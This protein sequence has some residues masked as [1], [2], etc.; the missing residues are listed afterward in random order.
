MDRCVDELTD[1]RMEVGE[2]LERSLDDWIDM[3]WQMGHLMAAW[4][5]VGY[6]EGSLILFWKHGWSMSQ[7]L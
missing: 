5:V 3:G 6:P 4:I 1:E 2:W 7:F